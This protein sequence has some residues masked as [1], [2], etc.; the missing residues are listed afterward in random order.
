MDTLL[1]QQKRSCKSQSTYTA[2]LLDLQRQKLFYNQRLAEHLLSFTLFF[3]LK[4][5]KIDL[6]VFCLNL[7]LM[8]H[9]TS[10]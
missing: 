8:L 5:L 4:I 10:L 6:E 9:N 1:F 2:A 3:E 7:L